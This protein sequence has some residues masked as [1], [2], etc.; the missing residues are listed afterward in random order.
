M[1]KNIIKDKNGYIEFRKRNKDIL[2]PSNPIKIYESQW[3]NWDDFLGYS[4]YKSFVE[5][6]KFIKKLKINSWNEY[7]REWKK[8]GIKQ[9]IPSKPYNVYKDEWNGWDDFLGK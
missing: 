9:K 7:R 6:K 2:L 5:S 1:R 3:V 8:F 4:K